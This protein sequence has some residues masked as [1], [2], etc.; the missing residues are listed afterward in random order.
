MRKKTERNKLNKLIH[1]KERVPTLQ[2]KSKGMHWGFGQG[3]D[4]GVWEQ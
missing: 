1:P 2:E 3:V 4:A